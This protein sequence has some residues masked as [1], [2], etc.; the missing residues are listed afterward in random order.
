MEVQQSITLKDLQL[1][2]LRY[3]ELYEDFT[4]K[5]SIIVQ[6][7]ENAS[8][9][10]YKQ[11][12]IEFY[13]HDTYKLLIASSSS[14]A[15]M[16]LQKTKV[17]CSNEKEY[18]GTAFIHIMNI[19]IAVN[20][21]ASFF[22]FLLNSIDSLKEIPK[23]DLN[24]LAEEM[25]STLLIDTSHYERS[26]LIFLR[27][28][29]KVLPGFLAKFNPKKAHGHFNCPLFF[30]NLLEEYMK[31]SDMKSYNQL[32]FK[33]ALT[34]LLRFTE[35][36]KKQEKKKEIGGESVNLGSKSPNIENDSL[37]KGINTEELMKVI[38]MMLE[39][40]QRYLNYMPLRL[41][42]LCKI[43]EK[44]ITALYSNESDKKSLRQNLTELLFYKWWDECLL[45]PQENE[46]LDVPMEN[47]LCLSLSRISR[48]LHS[49]FSLSKTSYELTPDLTITQY[50][51]S[52]KSLADTYFIELL[53]IPY[54]DLSE[55]PAPNIL[56]RNLCV[57][58]KSIM[59]I[60]EALHANID[61]LEKKS[62]AITRHV[63]RLHR[64]IN[65]K[66][67]VEGHFFKG[68]SVKF[69]ADTIE[70]I[71]ESEKSEYYFLFQ[72][73]FFKEYFRRDSFQ[74]K[75]QRA[76]NLLLLEVDLPSDC[77]NDIIKEIIKYP[78]LYV[79]AQKSPDKV[80]LL[81]K[82]LTKVLKENEMA[83]L[84][85]K[86]RLVYENIT[87]DLLKETGELEYEHYKMINNLKRQSIS[88]NQRNDIYHNK[89]IIIA[90]ANTIIKTF[91]MPFQ[92]LYKKEGP[93]YF[94]TIHK[95]KHKTSLPANGKTVKDF[96]AFLSNVREISSLMEDKDDTHN[97]KKIY[98]VFIKTLYAKLSN[99][100]RWINEEI[101]EI[102][103]LV[104]GYI[105]SKLYSLVFPFKPTKV[106]S[107]LQS[108]MLQLSKLKN[109]SGND[110][111]IP[112]EIVKFLTMKLKK[113]SELRNPQKKIAVY[114]EVHELIEEAIELISLINDNGVSY[115]PSQVFTLIVLKAALPHLASDVNY[116]RCFMQESKE[117]A[118]TY[119]GSMLHVI[120]SLN[121]V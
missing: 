93:K 19:L 74:D 8:R 58:L 98:K 54:P 55:P 111:V 32:L 69:I 21:D 46:L 85:E 5:R 102:V 70:E 79:K 33:D 22:D 113:S 104:R 88:L 15:S 52:K 14:K 82:Y 29:D 62:E 94:I 120:N 60:Q 99:D 100:E 87:N 17:L 44:H 106:D 41:R 71:K 73:V 59:I 121:K 20:T 43:I 64:L 1:I 42:Y 119:F 30:N 24:V 68:S 26:R 112:K 107:L 108:K 110:N 114:T 116:I 25:V 49:I 13:L 40:I 91:A 9:E 92:I 66:H 45:Y 90:S 89:V 97:I 67:K 48:I 81:G 47:E 12:I 86:M 83:E 72:D 50:I 57:S 2:I 38:D 6:E 37:L 103:L 28:A 35:E 53:N 63:K 84:M 11:K 77:T 36:N 7:L 3:N 105:A 101:K 75:S 51:E 39:N 34:L 78:L 115:T 117:D 31:Q 76:L 61:E 56:L 95:T 18:L 27:Y 65:S 4:H 109:H 10:L 118:T 23:E 16:Q 96:I 80:F